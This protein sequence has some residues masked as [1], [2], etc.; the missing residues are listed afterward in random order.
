MITTRGK[1][2]QFLQLIAVSG[3]QKLQFAI[4]CNSQH[5]ELT[6]IFLERK[7]QLF[8]FEKLLEKMTGRS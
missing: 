4:N 2:L 3:G 1:N 7:S 5:Y 6:F 8:S